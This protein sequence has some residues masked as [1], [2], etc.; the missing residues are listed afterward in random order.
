MKLLKLSSKQRV[1]KVKCVNIPG[2]ENGSSLRNGE[3]KRG[4]VFI[5]EQSKKKIKFIK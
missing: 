2:H 4:R 3:G 1:S 5:K